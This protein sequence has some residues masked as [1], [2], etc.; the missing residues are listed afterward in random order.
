MQLISI[1]FFFKGNVSF[2]EKEEGKVIIFYYL[3]IQICSFKIL[4]KFEIEYRI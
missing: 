4:I 3:I 1:Q 2:L